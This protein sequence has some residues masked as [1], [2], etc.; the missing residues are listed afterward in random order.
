MASIIRVG[1]VGVLGRQQA[2][3]LLTQ[4]SAPSM[5]QKCNISSKSVRAGASAKK[6]KPY[7]YRE[8]GYGLLQAMLDKTTKRLDENSK[9]IVVE[10]PIAA[11]KSKFAKELA[12][13]L[14]MLYVPQK[15]LD[16]FFINEYGYDMRKLDS[17]LPESCRSFDIT[18][19]CR[20]PKNRLV[21][22]FQLRMYQQRYSDYVDA[23]AHILST[24]Q[25]VVMNRCAYSDMVFLEAM[26]KHGYVSKGARSYYHEV[27]ENTISEL[28]KP[29]LV[30]Y[31]DVPVNIVKDRI[32][33]RNNDY[34]TK[35]PAL[36]D[37]YL[38]DVEQI[39]KQQYL[40][41]ISTHAELLVYDWSAG[42]ETEIV[43]EDIERIDFLKFEEDKHNK[44]MKDWRFPKEWDWCEARMLF[45]HQKHELMNYFNVPRYDVP[46]LLRSPEDSKIWREVWYNAPGMKYDYGY[47]EDMGDSG[48]LTKTKARPRIV[49]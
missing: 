25:G 21:A 30:I 38:N 19:F 26:F 44:K 3:A 8:K 39:Y 12:D 49:S 31:L 34:E 41:D 29:H 47:N 17:Q 48:L 28:L 20:D 32:R 16:L 45:A 42:G 1:I 43:V 40:K 6:P 11:G 24:G 9:L 2:A 36:T 33:A 23:L 4:A 35:S 22:G 46:E 10:G 15:N 37:E 27:R 13:E 7:P 5:M 14:E 18:N